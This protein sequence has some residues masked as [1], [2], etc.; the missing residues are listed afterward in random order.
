MLGDGAAAIVIE[1]RAVAEARGVKI[2]GRVAGIGEASGPVPDDLYV[3]SADTLAIAIAAALD[4]AE[5][6]AAD[7]AAAVLPGGLDPRGDRMQ[8]EALAADARTRDL[9]AVCW[10][11]ATGNMTLAS[12]VA[13]IALIRLTIRLERQ[14]TLL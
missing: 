4:E 11:A 6:D 5:C 14:F 8:L 13:E 12:E 10:R 9:P 2:L 7:L 3:P 1:S